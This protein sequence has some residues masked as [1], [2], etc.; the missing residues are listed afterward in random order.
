MINR[1]PQAESPGVQGPGDT[2]QLAH[3]R[4]TIRGRSALLDIKR[5][6]LLRPNGQ[7]SHASALLACVSM[8][9]LLSGCVSDLDSRPARET[10]EVAARRCQDSAQIRVDSN[11]GAPGPFGGGQKVGT[12][13]GMNSPAYVQCMAAAGYLSAAEVA[14]PKP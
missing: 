5:L 3:E 2:A 6:L 4:L 10:Y 12:A 14:P 11:V 13:V 1:Q 7:S 9:Q 8:L